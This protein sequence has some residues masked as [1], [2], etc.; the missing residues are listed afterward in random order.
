MPNLTLGPVEGGSTNLKGY[1]A[2]PTGDGPWPAVVVMQELWGLDEVLRR[3]CDRLASAGYL[4]F[5]PNL[6]SDGGARRCLVATFKAVLKGEGKAFADIEAARQL[7]LSEPECTGKIG[8]IG[9]CLG[10]AFA[11]LSSTRGFDVASD[12]YGGLP[13]HLDEMFGGAC[14]IIATYGAKDRL[15]PSGSATKL[16]D[17][18]VAAGVEHDVRS[19]PGA[20]HQFL[21]DAMNG[22]KVLR[23]LLKV[24]NAGPDPAAAVQAWKRIDEFFAQHL[25]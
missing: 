7:L 25:R 13:P 14:P 23:P 8:I 20:G 6:F 16:E 19:Y 24:T 9:F 10:G 17:A 21:N 1:L 5:A 3:H 18:L 12:N 15:L 11:L 22:P 4:A 2:R